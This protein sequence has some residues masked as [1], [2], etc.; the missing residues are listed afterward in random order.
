VCRMMGDGAFSDLLLQDFRFRIA[1][2]KF[3]LAFDRFGVENTKGHL[4]DHI[5]SIKV[6]MVRSVLTDQFQALLQLNN[7][8]RQSQY[9]SYSYPPV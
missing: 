9:P 6:I 2:C 8:T 7:H 5:E 1:G 4:F 3:R